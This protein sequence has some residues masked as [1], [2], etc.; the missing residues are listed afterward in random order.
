MGGSTDDVFTELK[1][2]NKEFL[3]S[4]DKNLYTF[5]IVS[6]E[7]YTDKKFKELIKDYR[8]E[9]NKIVEINKFGEVLVDSIIRW[10]SKT[11]NPNSLNDKD[12][13]I[14]ANELARLEALYSKYRK[15][16]SVL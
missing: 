7:Y 8:T 5:T 12:K 9:R 13:E 6:G 14:L 3:T 16:L 1:N 2:I 15:D 10:I 4:T 11:I